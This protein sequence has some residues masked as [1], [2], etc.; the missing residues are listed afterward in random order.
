MRCVQLLGCTPPSVETSIDT[1]SRLARRFTPLVRCIVPAVPRA[2]PHV[3]GST[4]NPR[5][6]A[7]HALPVHALCGTAVTAS[8]PAQLR[9]VTDAL[10]GKVPDIFNI[11]VFGCKVQA[12]IPKEHQKK[13]DATTQNG[14][15]VDY[16]TS[17]AYSVHFHGNTAGGTV[18]ARQVEFYE[19][20]F[21][22]APVRA[23]IVI[24]IQL[25]G[26]VQDLVTM[27]QSSLTSGSRRKKN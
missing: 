5:V 4:A 26:A 23:E 22:P 8:A 27:H 1:L 19:Y 25:E 3:L 6:V 13:Q 2:Q 21:L 18:I 10:L 24:N 11:R 16:A 14:I 15:F 12:L 17:G 9:P 7:A 20:R